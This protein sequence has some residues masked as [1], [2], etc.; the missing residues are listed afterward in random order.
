MRVLALDTTTRAG[1]VALVEDDRVVD[2]RAR[3]SVADARR[4]AAR[5]DPARCSTRTVCALADVD[6][7][8]V[9]SGPGIVHRPAHR[10]RDDAG[11][12]VRATAGRSSACRRSRRSR[13]RRRA[14]VAAG[15]ARRGLDG[16]ASPRR[17]RG[18]VSRSDR[19]RR[20]T[21]DRLI[22]IEGPTVGD[23][24]ATLARW[25][26]GSAAR[27]RVFV[28]DGA[29]LY[30]RHHSRGRAGGTRR[31]RRRSL[32]GAIGRMAV[33]RA[34]AGETHRPGG[35]PAAVRPAARRRRS[36]ESKDEPVGDRRMP[37]SLGRSS[38]STDRQPRSTTVLAIE[39]A[40][41]TNPWTR[42]MYL[43][44]LENRGVSFCYLARD[45]AARR[46]RLLLVLA[47]ARRAAHQQP[48]G[49]AG[50]AG[51]RASASALLAH[52]LR[53]GRAARRARA[54]RSRCG[55]RTTR[56]ALLY[57]RFGFSVAGVRRGVLHQA[58]R[59]RAGAVAR[60][61]CRDR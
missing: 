39:D 12:R 56:R 16:R 40:S 5:R 32:A 46:R 24:A 48:G 2:E 19:R 49:G 26:R 23:P 58:G 44:E 15:R 20:S 43:A 29:V 7:F 14:I 21:P 60:A 10:H 53:R 4:A 30:A 61:T 47:R 34:R 8:A 38:R 17:V 9:A 13:S 59:G 35:G 3:R 55:A 25:A 52:V 31:R 45:D 28:G 6:L 54:R 41:F 1:S 57:E 36:R 18:A 22:E 27:R 51:G 33:A 50:A 11:T 37:S 42:E